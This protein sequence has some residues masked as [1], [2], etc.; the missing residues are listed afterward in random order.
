MLLKL[1]DK[2]SNDFSELLNDRQE[3]NVAIEV[4]SKETFFAH[5]VV[6]RHRSPY[7]NKEL[8]NVDTNGNGDNSI[9]PVIKLNLSAQIF[10]II[11]K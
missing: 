3:Y 5:S 9:K 2:L 1:L 11:L 10:E 7:F 4:E 6:L 8:S